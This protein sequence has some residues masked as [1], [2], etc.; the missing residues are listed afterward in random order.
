VMILHRADPK[1]SE[2]EAVGFY[3][4][5]WICFYLPVAIMGTIALARMAGKLRSR[6]AVT[7]A[8]LAAVL[9]AMFLSF[10]LDVHF[11]VLLIE[12]LVFAICFWLLGR[13]KHNHRTRRMHSTFSRLGSFGE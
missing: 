8:S 2:P 12:Y 3:Y 6:L 10:Y 7:F 4:G 1:F 5:L 9:C 11:T 13:S